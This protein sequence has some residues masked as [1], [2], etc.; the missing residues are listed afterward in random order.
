M[1]SDW[2]TRQHSAVSST[3]SSDTPTD[4]HNSLSQLVIGYIVSVAIID[5]WWQQASPSQSHIHWC[6][7]LGGGGVREGLMGTWEELGMGERWEE[8]GRWG[9]KQVV[10][11]ATKPHNCTIIFMLLSLYIYRKLSRFPLS[12]S[13]THTLAHTCIHTHTKTDRWTHTHTGTYMHS[14]TYKD[15]QMDTHTHTGTYMHSHTYKDRHMDTHTHT[16]THWHIHA[17]TH[18]QRQTGTHTHTHTLSL[19]HTHQHLYNIWP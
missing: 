19:S 17:F 15:R 10:G 9:C 1:I 11:T 6:S 13:L 12:L 18:I 14:H 2:Q 5:W 16:R 3:S 8:G 4:K 7:V